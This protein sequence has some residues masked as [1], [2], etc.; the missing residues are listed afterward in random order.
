MFSLCLPVSVFLSVF[1]CLPLCLSGFCLSLSLP[2][3]VCLS[4][5]LLSVGLCFCFCLSS[6]SVF[7]FL[8]V[9]LS[10]CLSLLPT[11]FI[12]M[13][14][15]SSEPVPEVQPAATRSAGDVSLPHVLR[16]RVPCGLCAG[17][18]P[19]LRRFRHRRHVRV[20]NYIPVGLHSYLQ[21]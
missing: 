10:V 17:L 14:A 20:W 21:P 12:V 4:L 11:P 9:H 13:L 3:S 19:Q 8:S 18:P 15:A 2:L 1:V 7:L 6:L 16:S 5:L